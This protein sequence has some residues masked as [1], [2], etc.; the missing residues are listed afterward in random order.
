MDCF[1]TSE[2]KCTQGVRHGAHFTARVQVLDLIVL[3]HRDRAQILYWV[4]VNTV[5]SHYSEK[6]VPYA[7]TAPGHQVWTQQ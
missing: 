6:G 7:D 4:L 3:G 2:D 5:C 1:G